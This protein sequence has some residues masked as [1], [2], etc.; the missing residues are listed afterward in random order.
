MASSAGV[1]SVGVSAQSFT[2][3]MTALQLETLPPESMLA[4]RQ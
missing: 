4:T 2:M 1:E 3:L